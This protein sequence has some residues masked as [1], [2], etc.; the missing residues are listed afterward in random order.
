MK[1]VI[2]LIASIGQYCTPI[3]RPARLSA[4]FITAFIVVLTFLSLQS[5]A[6]EPVVARPMSEAWGDELVA[7]N[8][9]RGA[10]DQYRSQ[11]SAW[12]IIM[13]ASAK[14]GH[15]DKKA[16]ENL[17]RL[18]KKMADALTKYSPPPAV[19]EGAMF[20]AQKGAAFVKLAKDVRDYQAA[21]EQF[22]VALWQAPW[23]SDFHY[24]LAV[25]QKNAGQFEPALMSLQFAAILAK[26]KRDILALRAEIEAM[27]EIQ[28]RTNTKGPGTN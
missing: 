13:R 21:A 19:P 5:Y 20:S 14:N 10:F 22:E 8:Q 2:L 27:S 26:D 1:P 6:Q 3:S 12:Q 11:W 4:S 15:V 9:Y 23:V 16:Q 28:N 24:N 25:C 17:V 7:K 18:T